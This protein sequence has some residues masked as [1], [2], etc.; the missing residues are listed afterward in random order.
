MVRVE[1]SSPYDYYAEVRQHGK[2]ENQRPWD[3]IEIVGKFIPKK[4]IVLDAGTGNSFKLVELQN[5]GLNEVTFIG[6]DNKFYF[7]TEISSDLPT[8][9]KL[10]REAEVET[11][12]SPLK[13]RIHLLAADTLPGNNRG[14]PFE[15]ECF[16][17]VLFMLSTPNPEESFRVLQPGGVVIMEVVGEQDKLNIKSAF[18]VDSESKPRGYKM[19]YSVNTLLPFYREEFEAEGFTTILQSSGKWETRYTPYQLKELLKL[20]GNRLVKDY[21]EHKDKTTVDNIINQMS[22]KAGPFIGMIKTHQHRL[23]Y[24]GQKP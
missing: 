6:Y 11:A 12:K 5:R 17:A 7:Q 13:D 23:L 20:L 9:S 22:Y 19:E 4:G 8:P 10:L 3:F 21:D 14:M 15:D 1:E 16:D 24:V 2:N 18:G